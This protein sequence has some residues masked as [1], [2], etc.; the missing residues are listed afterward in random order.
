M[1]FV[2]VQEQ[3]RLPNPKK[4]SSVAERATEPIDS[5][6]DLTHPTSY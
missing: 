2:E 5:E 6:Q 4:A 3:S 1:I